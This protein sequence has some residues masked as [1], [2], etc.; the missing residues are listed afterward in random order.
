MATFKSDIYSGQFPTAGSANTGFKIERDVGGK[1][2]YALCSYTTVGTEV[3]SDTVQL[4]SLP[5][6]CKV[7]YWDGIIRATASL[8]TGVTVR[9]GDG[10]TANRWAGTIDISAGGPFLWTATAGTEILAPVALT[11]A[12]VVTLT[13]VA[14][15][16]ITAGKVIF[17]AVPYIEP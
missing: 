11:A 9:I 8:G 14:I 2:R 7:C 10:T 5:V 15:T 17:V 1:T 16:S 13:F 4:V 6:G 3:T 12:T